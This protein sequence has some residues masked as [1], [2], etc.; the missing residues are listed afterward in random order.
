MAAAR[1][2]GREYEGGE[3]LPSRE[4]LRSPRQALDDEEVHPRID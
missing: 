2:P 3:I 1:L 4:L